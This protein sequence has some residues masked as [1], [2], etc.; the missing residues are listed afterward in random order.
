MNAANAALHLLRPVGYGGLAPQR[1]DCN[2]A[3]EVLAR[4]T[5]RAAAMQAHAARGARLIAIDLRGPFS[6][7][8]TCHPGPDA[9]SVYSV[10]N[11]SIPDV[12]L[13]AYSRVRP[14]PNVKRVS[15]SSPSGR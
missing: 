11:V 15:F 10:R 6:V 9:P 7:D 8:G 3:A 2:E 14:L 12:R 4:D 1:S 13:A 5:I